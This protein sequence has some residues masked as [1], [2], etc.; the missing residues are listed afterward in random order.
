M[1]TTWWHV[2]RTALQLRLYCT[3]RSP[4]T[5]WYLAIPFRPC[6]IFHPT[7]DAS[8]SLTLTSTHLLMLLDSTASEGVVM[9]SASSQ[10]SPKRVQDSSNDLKQTD[11]RKLHQPILLHHSDISHKRFRR[12]H[13][14]VINHP[15]R[16]WLA[17]K[18]D[19]RRMDVQRLPLSAL[20]LYRPCVI[21]HRILPCRSIR[22]V[23]HHLRR[24]LQI[25][26]S[27]HLPQL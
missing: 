25:S 23:R 1:H 9:R 14:F 19:R 22:S 13:H 7:Q 18:H 26:Q 10:L 17:G 3:P 12:L 6:T 2:L 20:Y 4:I 11:S 8:L 27:S 15:A 24:V 16:R 5:L 21:T